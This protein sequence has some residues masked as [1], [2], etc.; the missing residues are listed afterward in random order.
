MGMFETLG[1]CALRRARWG[2]GRGRAAALTGFEA[3]GDPGV[4]VVPRRLPP[5]RPVETR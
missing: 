3:R 4:A 1:D 5:L 2:P